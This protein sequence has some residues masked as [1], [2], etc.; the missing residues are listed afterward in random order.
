MA[1]RTCV[2]ILFLRLPIVVSL[3]TLQKVEL[4]LHR[5]AF[6]ATKNVF[7][8]ELDRR[9][10]WTV[11]SLERHISISFGRPFSIN[12]RVID[13]GVSGCATVDNPTFGD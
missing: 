8:Q 9:L 12:D 13:A 5:E 2:R 11:Y 1:M 7:Q 10:F 4:G 3:L 6:Y